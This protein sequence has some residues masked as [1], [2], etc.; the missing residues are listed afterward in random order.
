MQGATDVVYICT[1]S[2]EAQLLS[3]WNSLISGLH[4]P[5]PGLVQSKLL[6]TQA[7]NISNFIVWGFPKVTRGNY[8]S[9]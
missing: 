3:K 2:E 1:H 6:S 7:L 9:R 4:V 5:L 8:I